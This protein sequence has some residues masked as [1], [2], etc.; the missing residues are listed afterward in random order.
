MCSYALKWQTT[1]VSPDSTRS[2]TRYIGEAIIRDDKLSMLRVDGGYLDA[3]HRMHYYVTDFQGNIT[4]TIS[5]T[6]RIEQAINYYPDGEPWIEPTGDNPFMFGGKERITFGNLRQYDFGARMYNAAVG[7]WWQQDPKSEDY[8]PIS[9]Y[10]FCG[11]N[12]VSRIEL[13]GRDWVHRNVNGIDEYYYDR[14]I[15]SQADLN[16]T[17]SDHQLTYISDGQSIQLGNNTYTF[18]NANGT[19]HKNDKFLDKT[20]I[21]RDGNMTIFGTS[22]TSCDP[23]TLHNNYMG[24]SYTG[25]DNPKDYRGKDSYEYEPL[26]R[27]E[28]ASI[29][30]D[31]AYEKAGAKGISGA[32]IDCRPEVIKADF[33]LVVDNAENVIYSPSL[34]DKGRSIACV[35]LF[36]AITI[37]KCRMYPFYTLCNMTI[38][39]LNEAWISLNNNVKNMLSPMNY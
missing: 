38:R 14:K 5:S 31:K 12:P 27:S 23:T 1:L 26:N 9:Q 13:D 30:H 17:K 24:T 19:V 29:K 36:T 10:V 25:P 16:K 33:N 22:A 11:G 2:V 39:T 21:H 28:K 6:G 7:F 15:K 32:F 37:E 35:A 34:L 8:Y 4:H 3:N 18:H 20:K